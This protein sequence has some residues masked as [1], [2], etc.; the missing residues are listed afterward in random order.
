M[1]ANRK[2][3]WFEF[4][5]EDLVVAKAALN[6][7]IFNLACFHAQQGVEKMLKGYLSVNGHDVPKIHSVIKILTLCVQIDRDFEKVSEVCM[8]LDDYYIPTRYPDALPGTG[9][10]GLPQRDDAQ[11]AIA[12]LEKVADFV[13]DKLR[14]RPKKDPA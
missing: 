3:N 2:S 5:R 9:S 1:N 8:L 10:K 4:A 6:E 11:E 14:E 7:K 13:N 12:V